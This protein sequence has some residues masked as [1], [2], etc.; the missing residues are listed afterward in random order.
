MATTKQIKKLERIALNKYEDL[1]DTI[2]VLEAMKAQT[3][4]GK[5]WKEL[6]D[7]LMKHV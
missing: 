5:E 2:L 7:K 6:K 1:L 4:P 3:K